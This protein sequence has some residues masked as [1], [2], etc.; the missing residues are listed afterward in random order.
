MFLEP[1]KWERA[2][3]AVRRAVG[4]DTF[5]ILTAFLAFVR[6][7]HYWTE[8]HPKLAIEPDM[9]A[10]LEQH[11]VLARLLYDPSDAECGKA[12]ER[13]RQTLAKL[14][15]VEASLRL[16][17][18]TLKVAM[19]SAGLFAWEIDR[20]TRC[21]KITGDPRLAFGFD[22]SPSDQERFVHVHPGDLRYL[23]DAC[24]AIFAG[25][26]PCDLEHRV[27]NPT[28]GE[29]MW[30]HWTGRLV[31]E[32]GRAKL[33][34]IT[35]NVTSRKNDELKRNEVETALRESKEQFRWLASIVESSDDAII[36]TD[37]DAIATSWNKGAERLFGYL[38]EETI[39]KPVAMLIPPEREHEEGMILSGVRRGDRV[40]HFETVRRRKD[41]TLID[42][43][44]TV[45]P[46]R[47]ADGKVVGA[48]GISRDITERKRS[49]A[50]VSVL[51]RE[52]EHRAKNLLANV[53]AMVQLSQAD[54][55]DGLKKAIA[56]RIA[57]LAGVHS[58]F[59]KSRWTGAE[60]GSLVKQ[61]LS[62]YSRDGRTQIDGP[63][64]ML[65]PDLA[66][67]I[68][69]ALHELATNAAKYGA[70]SLAEGRVRV[71]WSCAA[72]R[73][74]VLRWTEAGGPP[75]NPPT[76]KGF[77]T[78]MIETMIRGHKGGDARL[79]WRAE[80]LA[81]EIILPT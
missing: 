24:E 69:V 70:L 56:G 17:R 66:Q 19:Q 61:E 20:D 78:R 3:E 9:L 42:I 76:R 65:K 43:S 62:P 12:G 77:G 21:M 23:R 53:G 52:A 8:T 36:G 7:A 59:A 33:V 34:G 26:A 11:D 15:D 1:R 54:T 67:A 50:Q 60:L 35:R 14:Q 49:E 6:T 63:S 57:A 38:A 74:L 41:G 46:I 40:D 58:L 68:G 80:G 4:D 45:S 55:P 25:K 44:L 28:T 72:D 16:S 79:N 2:G 29:V 18:E 30:A 5:E 10:V 13:L 73:Q 27:I 81:C 47:G 64:V 37:L 39:G 22:V 71:E 75:V 48:S 31:T 51:A 32:T